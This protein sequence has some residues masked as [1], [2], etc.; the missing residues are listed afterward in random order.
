MTHM[1]LIAGMMLSHV[2]KT[3]KGQNS[4]LPT[5]QVWSPRFGANSPYCIHRARH[6]C[7]RNSL[8]GAMLAEGA[9]NNTG[10]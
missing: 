6:R 5:G 8:A 3:V 2:I 10:L 1:T 7:V 9:I 4:K